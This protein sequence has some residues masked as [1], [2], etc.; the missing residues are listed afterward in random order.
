MWQPYGRATRPELGD[1]NGSRWCA[2]QCAPPPSAERARIETALGEHYHH[3]PSGGAVPLPS[4]PATSPPPVCNDTASHLVHGPW[5][6]FKSCSAEFSVRACSS[7]VWMR[8]NCRRTCHFCDQDLLSLLAMKPRAAAAILRSQRAKGE[9]EA[10]AA[11]HS[12]REETA[13]PPALRRKASVAHKERA[14]KRGPLS[15]RLRREGGRGAG[16]GDGRE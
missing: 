14:S 6:D 15:R 16:A 7:L 1:I 12:D 3:V 11:E 8:T 2:Q 5:E 9:G 4:A 13:T 10:T